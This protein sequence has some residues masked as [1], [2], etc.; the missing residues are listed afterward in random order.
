MAALADLRIN[1]NSSDVQDASRNLNDLSRSTDQVSDSSNRVRADIG[2]I[3]SAL[4]NLKGILVGAVAGFSALATIGFAAGLVT[5]IIQVADEVGKMS[6]RTGVAAEELQRLMFAASQ[7]DAT[8]DDLAKG[9]GEINKELI[10][11]IS[12]TTQT[13][14]KFSALGIAIND[15]SGQAKTADQI[16]IEVSKAVAGASNDLEAARVASSVFGDEVG[17][18]LLPMLKM[19][20]DGIAAMGS[21]A[22]R[23]GI[24][25]GSDT[26]AAA[27]AFNDGLD[28][29]KQGLNGFVVQVAG[30]VIQV[31]SNLITRFVDAQRAGLSF[32]ESLK[33]SLGS[34]SVI[35]QL[36]TDVEDAY[37]TLEK[38]RRTYTNSIEMDGGADA[39]YL[40]KLE[41]ALAQATSR[42]NEAAQ[43]I[44]SESQSI[45]NAFTDLAPVTDTVTGSI[46][47]LAKGT[48]DTSDELGDFIKKLE[49]SHAA[50]DRI[51]AAGDPVYAAVQKGAEVWGTLTAAV[52]L[53]QITMDE[54]AQLYLKFFTQIENAPEKVQELTAAVDPMAAAWEEAGKRIDASFAQA[55]TGAFDSFKSFSNQIK[56]SLKSLLAEMA[57]MA[58][59]RPIL[60]QLGLIGGGGTASSVAQAASG[61]SSGGSILGSVA[62]AAS[63][64]TT[65]GAFLGTGF[66]NTIAGGADL[67]GNM[68]AG[69]SAAG[70]LMAN[71]SILS[72]AAMGLG[73]A[74][75]VIGGV[76]AIASLLGA[77]DKKPSNKAAGGSVDLSTGATDNLWAMSGKKAPSQGTLDARDGILSSIGGFSQLLTSLGGAL[78][79]AI[80]IDLGERDG[81]QVDF[82]DGQG[83]QSFGDDLESALD[84]ILNQLIQKADGLG[85]VFSTL[86]QGIEGG[87]N[88]IQM[89]Q[90]LA[91]LNTLRSINPVQA[92]RD[93]ITASN[94]TLTDL[95]GAQTVEVQNLIATYDGSL[96]STN[97]LASAYS[98]QIDMAFN[99]AGALLSARDQ[100]DSLFGSLAENIR[101]SLMGDEELYGYLNNRVDI[102]VQSLETMVDPTQIMQTAA[103]IERLTSQM[104][105]SLDPSQQASM[106]EGFLDFLDGVTSLAQE[107]IDTALA[108]IDENQLALSDG[109]GE[110]LQSAADIQKQA[111][112]EMD[113]AAQQMIAAAQQMTSAAI[114][115]GSAAQRMQAAVS[116]INVAVTVHQASSQVG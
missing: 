98:S 21:E 106:G 63:T 116:N 114:E 22:D 31:L 72:G 2:G 107:R 47:K 112:N 44:T 3:G 58:I 51:R 15:A 66:M 25:I 45:G 39:Q 33:F 18:Q 103:E 57:H 46:A 105:S 38:A 108:Q 11:T 43:S 82:G 77:F 95:Y 24:V 78:G 89:A 32:V 34:A 84:Q 65:A 8:N 16:F 48:K 61:G 50:L 68:S 40:N 52:E 101:Q 56:D 74:L 42:Y 4:G 99:L 111:A 62:Q 70:S 14:E 12:S 88:K 76:L 13:S 41:T 19:G 83:M 17:T 94:R 71:G 28:T 109:T 69:F 87:T 27:E 60:M 53:N 26:V 97:A 91:V 75:P 110:A 90:S 23:L 85:D 64:F 80:A 113:I 55:W 81:L 102:L 115:S 93:Q 7:S 73:T 100:I 104:W 35:E 86:L 1:L 49:S 29:I 92:V 36:A 79:G 20:E 9:L 10:S 5:D 30:P 96:E 37:S 59:S 67:I 54:A 6:T